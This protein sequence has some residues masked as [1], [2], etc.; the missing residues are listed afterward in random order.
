MPV[1]SYWLEASV[2]EL[3]RDARGNR[4]VNGYPCDVS[5]RECISNTVDSISSE[6]GGIDVLVNNAGIVIPGYFEKLSVEDFETVPLDQLLRRPLP[7]I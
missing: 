7:T 2:E 3:S 4:L 5:D 1:P 6:A